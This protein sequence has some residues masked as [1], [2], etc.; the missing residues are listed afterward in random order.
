MQRFH[1]YAKDSAT[2]DKLS[3]APISQF[4]NFPTTPCH[5][6]MLKFHYY[7]KGCATRDNPSHAP[8]SQFPNFPISQIPSFPVLGKYAEISLLRKRLHHTC[9]ALACPNF[10]ISQFP[11]VPIS[12]FPNFPT[13]PCS[14]SM[15][16]SHYYAKGCTTRD[17]IS[18][19][20]I[21][22][23]PNFPISQPPHAPKV[24]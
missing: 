19:A 8:I 6:I 5:T 3:H 1:Y 4:P 17:R 10:T 16:K 24:C 21:S 15:L 14:E 22:K 7:G 20:P 9:Q 13:S 18:H 23:F 11:N 2:R 12:Q